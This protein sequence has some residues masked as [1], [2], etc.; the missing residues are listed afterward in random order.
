MSWQEAQGLFKIDFSV[1]EA[2]YKAAQNL[3][4]E[5][6]EKLLDA[7]TVKYGDLKISIVE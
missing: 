2:N 6:A 5:L 4:P 3:K 1:S 7:R